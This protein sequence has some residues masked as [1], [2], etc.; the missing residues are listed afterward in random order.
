MNP[1][2]IGQPVL[3]KVS[4]EH[5]HIGEIRSCGED[6]LL[7]IYWWDGSFSTYHSIEDIV[8]ITNVSWLE[9]VD[10]DKPIGRYG[11]P[12]GIECNEYQQR[13]W[14]YRHH[15]LSAIAIGDE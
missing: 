12:E 1:L 8:P 4:N 5:D 13:C 14:P 6:G 3:L 15:K 11:F 7:E 9:P 10:G 2:H